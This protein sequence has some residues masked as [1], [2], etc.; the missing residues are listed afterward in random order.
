MLDRAIDNTQLGVGIA[1]M[2]ERLRQLGGQL[3]IR[4]SSKGTTVIAVLPRPQESQPVLDQQI[5]A[6]S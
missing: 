4:S 6:F 3:E 1:G 2:R 5:A